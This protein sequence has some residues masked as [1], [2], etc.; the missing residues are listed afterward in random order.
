M[1]EKKVQLWE[2]K[3]SYEM[4]NINDYNGETKVSTPLPPILHTHTHT[5]LPHPRH[6]VP[7]PLCSYLYWNRLCRGGSQ[8][9]IEEQSKA[10][11]QAQY[12]SEHI[13]KAQSM[14]VFQAQCC[15]EHIIEAQSMSVFQAQCC[16]GHII[17][18]QSMAVFQAQCCSGH[19]WSTVYG[20]FPGTVLQWA[21]YWSTVWPFSRH[22]AAMSTL[23]KHSLWPFS[24][25]SAAM[26]T[27]LK[28]SLAV[29]QAQCCNEHIIEAQS[30]AVFQA[31]CCS[32]A[33]LSFLFP[34]AAGSAAGE[35]THGVF[36][37]SIL[38]R[39]QR[40]SVCSGRQLQVTND[41]HRYHITLLALCS[42]RM[43]HY[44]V[45]VSLTLWVWLMRQLLFNFVFLVF[46]LIFFYWIIYCIFLLLRNIFSILGIDLCRKYC[47]VFIM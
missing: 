16:S 14:A 43:E 32:E 37:L 13:I 21:H 38:R 27:L 33:H 22:S 2:R 7:S 4:N 44:V 45:L 28:H 18:A 25:H 12:C 34:F 39:G 15:S 17:E 20:R 31:H 6:F 26:S 40:C 36:L 11:F 10:V 30:V 1:T 41:S 23:L 46:L 19:Y 24:R 35:A 47:L 29:F 8:H 3:K 42:S 9:I 5:H